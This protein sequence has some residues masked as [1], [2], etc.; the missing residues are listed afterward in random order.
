MS[1]PKTRLGFVGAGIMG[2]LHLQHFSRLAD[3]EMAAV[4]DSNPTR[5]ATA[6]KTYDIAQV[7]SDGAQLI[8]DAD[9]GG[10]V[11]SVPNRLHAP[12]AIAALR[13]GRMQFP[14]R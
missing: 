7:Y 11:I 6:Q 12:L 5:L 1:E 2:M 10:V 3:V 4:A 9:L 13:A 14:A 8:A